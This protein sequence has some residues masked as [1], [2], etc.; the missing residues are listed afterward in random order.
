MAAK[1]QTFLRSCCSQKN[2]RIWTNHYTVVRDDQPYRPEFACSINMVHIA[3]IAV[4]L[5]NVIL[6][7][8]NLRESTSIRTSAIAM[9]PLTT[10][11]SSSQRNHAND[12]A[13]LDPSQ[14]LICWCIIMSGWWSK[15]SYISTM[16]INPH[17]HKLLYIF[18]R[19]H[20]SQQDNTIRDLNVFYIFFFLPCCIVV[21]FDFIQYNKR[22]LLSVVSQLK[23][24]QPDSMGTA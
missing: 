20:E 18:V 17:H 7:Q 19:P 13:L 24:S 6:S 8:I 5:P 1:C 23:N 10:D 4:F 15:L 16:K 11:H 14:M 9:W 22:F 2:I 12:G 3:Q 21:M